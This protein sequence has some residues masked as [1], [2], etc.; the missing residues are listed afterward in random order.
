MLQIKV[1]KIKSDHP[2]F[3]TKKLKK[4]LRQTRKSSVSAARRFRL[5]G[6]GRALFCIQHTR[7][8]RVMVKVSYTNNTRTRSWAAHGKYLQRDHA[9]IEGEKGHGFTK[10][11]QDID[12]SKLLNQWQEAGDPRIF[13]VIISPENA[14]RLDLQEHVRELMQRVEAD[15][16][17]SLEWVAI[18]HNNTE[19]GHVHLI[20]RGL[21]EQ[22]HPLKI[23]PEYIANGFRTQSQEIATQK[24]GLRT[25]HDISISRSRQI[26][27]DYVTAIDR[28]LRFKS[29]DGVI[30]FENKLPQS[31]LAKER[32][33][34]EIKRL[35]YL[36][37]I[38]L[39]TK[40]GKKI[41]NLSS[42][43]ET[44]LKN[45]QLSNDIIK[46][47]ARRGLSLSTVHSSLQPT[48][49]S[50]SKPLTGKVMDMGLEN[51]LHDKR[52]LLLEGTDGQLHYIRATNNI[53][54][55]RDSQQFK[56]GDVITLS[57]KTF[58]QKDK[59]VSYIEVENHQVSK[60]ELNR[61]KARE[62]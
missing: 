49:I 39:A 61:A 26:E 12:I 1:P 37:S 20:I 2:D 31:A 22:G 17:T 3:V 55:A 11:S 38:G 42:D 7:E 15:L 58:L 35:K 45:M 44:T 48:V 59:T 8:Q 16:G 51:E 33:L 4:L 5:D 57:K 27:K 23:E 19:H 36:E 18:D 21:D 29:V 60:K 30:T 9:Q 24:L 47:L 54:K 53:V 14:T 62:L 32:R 13:K 50:A 41:W 25:D 10:I 43:L 52:Y 46:S 34:Q 6:R 40:V 28:S 56:N